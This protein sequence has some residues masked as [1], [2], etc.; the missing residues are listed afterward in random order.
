MYNQGIV[1]YETFLPKGRHFINMTVHDFV[2]VF[3]DSMIVDQ[4]SRIRTDFF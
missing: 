3:L 2:I 1:V 4:H